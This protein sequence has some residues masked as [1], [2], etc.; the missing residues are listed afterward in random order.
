[1]R[2]T[3][4]CDGASPPPNVPEVKVITTPATDNDD[5]SLCECSQSPA[6]LGQSQVTKIS[7]IVFFLINSFLTII[8]FF[9]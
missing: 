5:D 1:M 9:N 4:I 8:L 6:L 3:A 7:C 2:G